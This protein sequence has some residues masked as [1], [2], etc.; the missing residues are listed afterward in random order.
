MAGPRA[1]RCV[2]DPAI[3]AMNAQ[4]AKSGYGVTPRPGPSRL[5]AA[6]VADEAGTAPEDRSFQPD[7]EGLRAMAIVIVLDRLRDR[8]AG[9]P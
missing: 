7:G 5:A 8:T 9:R 1:A 2:D 3:E 4:L 6:P